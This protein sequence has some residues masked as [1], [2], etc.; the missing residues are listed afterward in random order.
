MKY[1]LDFILELLK[2]GAPAPAVIFTVSLCLSKLAKVGP[3]EVKVKI[4]KDSPRNSRKGHPP[5]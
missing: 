1:E 5:K 3:I 4:G 2:S